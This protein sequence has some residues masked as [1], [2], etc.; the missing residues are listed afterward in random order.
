MPQPK[1]PF[2]RAATSPAPD[3]DG[4]S[5]ILGQRKLIRPK[6]TSN[7]QAEHHNHFARSNTSVLSTRVNQSA[8]YPENSRTEALYFEKQMQMQTRMV[9]VLEDGEHLEGILEWH[10][11]NSIKL[12]D[13]NRRRSLIYKSG[14]KYLYKAAEKQQNSLMQ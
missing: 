7:A 4:D 3:T 8:S 11:R 2:P 10:D 12:S 5:S 13:G 9:V 6:L 1:R 14:I